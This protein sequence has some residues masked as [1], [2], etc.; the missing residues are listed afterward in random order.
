[1]GYTIYHTIDFSWLPN[2]KGNMRPFLYLTESS[3]QPEVSLTL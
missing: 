1:M 2:V 3:I